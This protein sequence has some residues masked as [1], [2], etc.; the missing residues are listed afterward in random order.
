MRFVNDQRG[1]VVSWI[2][3]LTIFLAVFCT[4]LFDAG[5]ITT[6]YFGLQSTADD[7]ALAMATIK[8]SG[9][10][11]NQRVL[12]E[13]AAKLAEE[14]DAKLISAELSFDGV[15]HI[16]LKRKATTLIVANLRPIRSWGRATVSGTASTN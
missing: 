5:A 14:A 16:R 13:E 9:D 7:I 12:E 4:V 1:V 8:E 6:N 11:F 10:T 3:K 2:V 15:I